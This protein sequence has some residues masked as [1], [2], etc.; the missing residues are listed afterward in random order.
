MNSMYKGATMQPYVILHMGISLDGR[1]DWGGG[2]DNPYYELVEQFCADTDISGSNTIL[3]ANFPDDPQ[4]VLGGVYDEWI[5]KPGRPMHAIVDSQGRIKNWEVI[6]KQPWWRD[7]VSLCS[8]ETPQSHFEY[9]R[10]A[11]I[12]YIIAGKHHVDLRIALEQLNLQFG[13]QRVR[14][15]SGGLLNGVLLREG[16]VDEVSVIISP[17]LVGGVTPKTMY[18]APDLDAEERVVRLILSHVE[19]IRDCY[20]WLRYKVQK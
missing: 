6:K 8:E 16:L 1:I 19:T 7:Y 14:V 13:T 3:Q 20:V 10:E 5:K 9:L 12:A 18:I 2:S 4:K 11:G 17:S 15:D